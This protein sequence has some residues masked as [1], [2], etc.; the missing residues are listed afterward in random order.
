V[1]TKPEATARRKWFVATRIQLLRRE[2]LCR[3]YAVEEDAR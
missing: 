2:K 3:V 1:E